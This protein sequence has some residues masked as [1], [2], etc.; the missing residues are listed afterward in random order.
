MSNFLRHSILKCMKGEATTSEVNKV[1]IA[2]FTV[3]ETD[4]C[5]L[6]EN[7]GN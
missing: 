7:F 6:L 2:V 1:L 4:N 3:A 5:Y